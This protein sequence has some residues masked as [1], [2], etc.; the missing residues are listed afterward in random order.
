MFRHFP[1]FYC[2]STKEAMYTYQVYFNIIPGMGSTRCWFYVSQSG[3]R[4][5]NTKADQATCLAPSCCPEVPCFNTVSRCRGC[6]PESW[7][8]FLIMQPSLSFGQE[9]FWALVVHCCQRFG[10]KPRHV[11][12]QWYYCP[13]NTIYQ[14]I[15]TVVLPF[16][17]GLNK[18]S[19]LQ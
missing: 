8:S 3:H 18:Q 13:R 14:V 4:I 11:Y 16:L 6:D 17:S 5:R 7:P 9:G 2:C 1:P 19:P 15:L 12:D 10:R